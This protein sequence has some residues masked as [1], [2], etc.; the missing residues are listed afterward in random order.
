MRDE[1]TTGMK[2]PKGFDFQR[3]YYLA[4]PMTGYEHFNYPAFERNMHELEGEAVTIKSPHTIPWPEEP[5][6]GEE[7]WQTMMRKALAMLLTC[8]GIILMRGWTESKGALVEYNIA[9]ALRMPVYFLDGKYVVPMHDH[10][11]TLVS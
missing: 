3:E 6:E 10:E 5:Q 8:N 11:R 9:T 1:E 7:L 4:G 2:L